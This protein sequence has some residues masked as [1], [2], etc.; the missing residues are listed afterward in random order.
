MREKTIEYYEV[1]VLCQGIKKRC[2][3]VDRAGFNLVNAPIGTR[4]SKDVQG[5]Y[6]A[7]AIAVLHENMKEWSNATIYF[8]YGYE[9]KGLDGMKTSEPFSEH[10]FTIKLGARA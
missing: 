1:R 8:T 7:D 5:Q 10:N 2:R 3:K 9:T 6:E 4:T